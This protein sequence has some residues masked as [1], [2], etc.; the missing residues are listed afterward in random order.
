MGATASVCPEGVEERVYEKLHEAFEEQRKQLESQKGEKQKLT[1]ALPASLDECLAYPTP[2]AEEQSL[3]AKLYHT[4]ENKYDEVVNQ[5]TVPWNEVALKALPE[6]IEESVYVHER[7]PM[8]LDVSGQGYRFLKYQNGQFIL[9]RSPLDVQPENLR[10]SLVS[11]IKHGTM[12]VV[13]FEDQEVNLEDLFDEDHFPREVLKKQDLFKDETLKRILR[14][15]AGDEEVDHFMPKDEFRFVVVTTLETDV[16]LVAGEY[17]MAVINVLD[18]NQKNSKQQNGASDLGGLA[19]A[20]AFG[21]KEVKR[22]STKLV[23]V[24]LRVYLQC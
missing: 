8:M 16:S 18:P 3:A 4:L 5:Y 7:W 9:A 23:E 13:N 15:D 22:N 12:L 14:P 2:K 10:K 1:C 24:W 20:E 6:A 17:N 21:A 19:I 11:C